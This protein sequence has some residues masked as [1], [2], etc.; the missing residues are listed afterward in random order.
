MYVLLW[1]IDEERLNL[2][3]VYDWLGIYWNLDV[4]INMLWYFEIFCDNDV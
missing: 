3:I 1:F 4:C 2:F